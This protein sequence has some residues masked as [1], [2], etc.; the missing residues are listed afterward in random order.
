MFNE[1]WPWKRELGE[2]AERLET[3]AALPNLG[4]PDYDDPAFDEED[5]VEAFY[6]VERDVMVGCF[7]VR[8]LIG[9]PSKVTKQ[10]RA[11]KA[12]VAQFPLRAGARIPDSY[13]ALGEL[14]MYRLDASTDRVIT[15]NDL[16]NLFVH[17]LIFKFAWTTAGLSWSEYWALGEDDPRIADPVRLAGFLVS[18]DRSRSEHL[19]FVE[20]LEIVRVFRDLANDD[21]TSLVIKQDHRGRRHFRAS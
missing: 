9:M 16:C 18:S 10:A 17:S 21:V 13:D 2:A 19:T 11:T 3:V 5:E 14:D 4:L 12:A 7:A 1:S 8:R 15:A 20:L 6:R